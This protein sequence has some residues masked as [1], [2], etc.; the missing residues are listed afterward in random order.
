MPPLDWERVVTKHTASSSGH[1]Y[2]HRPGLSIVTAASPATP[3]Q[4]MLAQEQV[5]DRKQEGSCQKEEEKSEEEWETG[6]ANEEA[7]SHRIIVSKTGISKD[8]IEEL[9]ALLKESPLVTS[10]QKANDKLNSPQR[11]AT[12][13]WDG[14][15]REAAGKLS[16][17]SKAYP[18]IPEAPSA[19]RPS[20]LSIK[21]KPSNHAVETPQ[22]QTQEKANIKP[23]ALI[24]SALHGRT[25][26]GPASRHDPASSSNVF[27]SIEES[28]L[29][30]SSTPSQIGF[31]IEQ[32]KQRITREDI[33]FIRFEASDLNGISRS[34]TIPARFFQEKVLHGVPM[35]RSYLELILSP[36][37]D[38][39]DHPGCNGEDIL[40]MPDISTF[41][42]LPWVE[43]TASVIC[44]WCSATGCP[45]PTSPRQVAKVQLRHLSALGLALRSSFTYQFCLDNFAQALNP[46]AALPAATLLNNH[47][48]SFA[49]ELMEGMYGAGVDVES[50]SSSRWPG[51][52][53]VAL[54]AESG[55]GAADNAF[56]FRTG[57]KELARKHQHNASF[58]S[59]LSY[60]NLGTLSH[61]LWEAG[62]RCNLF[63]RAGEDGDGEGLSGKARAWQAGL[64]LHAAAL[65]CLA[66]LGDAC[67]QR[68]SPG[69]G[70]GTTRGSDHTSWAFNGDGRRG[71]RLENRLGS[72]AANPYLVLAATVAAGLD[73]LTEDGAQAAKV[74]TIPERL[75]DALDALESDRCIQ[76]ALG[77]AF[78]QHFIA[79]KR[80]ELATQAPDGEADKY[81]EYFI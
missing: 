63:G 68:Y 43:K 4:P 45:L 49:Q 52:M 80:H 50:F 72:A 2:L 23:S 54:R 62:G 5:G 13:D 73:G 76:R 6:S 51:Q 37:E 39:A 77:E 10:R 14:K 9:K 60:G 11:L 57:L 35:P 28:V 56:A 21:D 46:P 53:E 41:R 12:K 30:T 3:A 48:Q 47:H 71:A 65:S 40:L 55:L 7:K 20:E 1:S 34:K 61:S 8:T 29:T 31:T 75:E 66:V 74:C 24:S 17:N 26:S 59:P 27:G 22:I 33:R 19:P 81:L 44:D 38:A 67:H 58:F 16:T 25:D 64:L 70:Q 42:V 36:K 69:K 18:G 15:S 32:V 79:V 78:T